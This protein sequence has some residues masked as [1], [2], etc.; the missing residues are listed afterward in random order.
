M[1]A[2]L[3]FKSLLVASLL[4]ACTTKEG[5]SIV[6][7]DVQKPES[8][9][10]ASVRITVSSSMSGETWAVDRRWSDPVLHLGVYLPSDVW[11]SVMTTGCGMDVGGR[12]I[13]FGSSNTV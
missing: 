8:I 1:L 4:G 9:P 3:A 6:Q 7:V 11:G 10:V 5:R 13:A 12:P 2:R